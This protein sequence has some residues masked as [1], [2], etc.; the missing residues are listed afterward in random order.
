MLSCARTREVLS[1]GHLLPFAG[2]VPAAGDAARAQLPAEGQ[3]LARVQ[4]VQ[5]ARPPGARWQGRQPVAHPGVH[6]A[7]S[8]R[9]RLPV[10]QRQVCLPEDTCA[11]VPKYLYSMCAYDSVGP[12]SLLAPLHPRKPCIMSPTVDLLISFSRVRH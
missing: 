3:D 12:T 1:K 2:R 9:R 5:S 11:S 10:Q 4:S 8:L 7:H 6:A